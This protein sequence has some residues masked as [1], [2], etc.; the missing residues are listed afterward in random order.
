MVHGDMYF[1]HQ[2]TVAQYLERG[3]QDLLSAH[4]DTGFECIAGITIGTAQRAAG[5]PNKYGWPAHCAAFSLQ[6]IENL[7]NA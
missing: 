7:G 2:G 4:T 5:Q 1:E 3:L 6:G